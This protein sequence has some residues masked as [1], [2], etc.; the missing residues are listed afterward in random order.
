MKKKKNVFNFLMVANLLL[1]QQISLLLMSSHDLTSHASAPSRLKEDLDLEEEDLLFF[2]LDFLGTLG[3]SLGPSNI[4]VSGS[5]PPEWLK[6]AQIT[7]AKITENVDV[8]TKYRKR[9][10]INGKFQSCPAYMLAL[11]SLKM[12]PLTESQILHWVVPCEDQEAIAT[13]LESP[14]CTKLLRDVEEKSEDVLYSCI[15]TKQNERRILSVLVNMQQL[16]LWKCMWGWRSYP[17][18]CIYWWS[19][20]TYMS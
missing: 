7:A 1:Q 9:D 5:S 12:F 4:S 3:R 13:E 18:W 19:I 2:L 17:A 14:D 11:S 16:Y 15:F 6:S 20:P 10:G 8:P